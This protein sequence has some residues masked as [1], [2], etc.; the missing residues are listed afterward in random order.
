MLISR[1]VQP[2]VACSSFVDVVRAGAAARPGHEAFLFLKDGETEEGRRTLGDLEV[3]ARRIGG[4]LQRH[5]PP[6]LRALLLYPPG[7]EFID[8]FLGCLFAG[9]IAVPAYPPRS[10]RGLPRLL[11]ILKD[12]RPTVILTT[13]SLRATLVAAVADS[14]D[15]QGLE[16]LATDDLG[17]G[18]EADWREPEVG[19]D[20]P[21]F[22]QYTSG[23]TSLPKGVIVS[24]GNLLHNEE[25]IRQAFRQ[26]GESVV[27]SWLPLYHDMGLIGGVLQPLFVGARCVLLSPVAFLQRP[28]RWLEAIDRYR[29]TTSGGPNFAYELCV[30]KVDPGWR[31]RLDLSSW[32]VAFNGAEPVRADTLERFARHFSPCGFRREAFYPCY[33]LAEATLL[34][35]AHAAATAPRVLPLEVEAL[36]RQRVRVSDEET[37]RSR[38]L[39]ASGRGY[40]EIVIVDGETAVRLPSDQIGEIWVASPSVAQG[41]WNRPEESARTFRARL[42]GEPE[43]GPFLRTGDLGFLE[44]GELFVTGRLK[45][46]IILR[47]RNY[48]PQDFEQTSEGY[49]PHFRRGGGAAFAVTVFGE[50]QLVVVQEVEARWSGDFAAEAEALRREVA[51][52]HGIQPFEV[53]LVRHGTVPRTSSG[54]VQ[55]HACRALYEEGTLEVLARHGAA[56]HGTAADAENAENP[57]IDLAGAGLDGLRL[58]GLA[59]TEQASFVASFLLDRVAHVTGTAVARIVLSEAPAN[60]GVDSLG[61]VELREAIETSLG[62]SVPLSAVMEAASLAALRDEILARLA[63]LAPEPQRPTIAPAPSGWAS[64][65][66]P[67][68]EGQNALWVAERLAPDSGVCNIAVAARTER[69]MDVERLRRAL[70]ALIDRHPSLR[71]RFGQVGGV[72]T[73][74]VLPPPVPVD[75]ALVGL[76]APTTL[77]TA[78]EDEAEF[79][80]RLA[81][82][83]FRP[84]DLETGPLVRVRIYRRPGKVSVLLFVVHHL[85]TDYWSLAVFLRELGLVYGQGE[86]PVRLPAPAAGRSFADWVYWQKEMLAGAEGRRLAA[87]W[88]ERL[89][90]DL[91]V[92]ELPTDRPRPFVQSFIAGRREVRIGAGLAAGVDR[93]AK[94]R[95]ATLYVTLL[96]AYQA[97]LARYTGT[98]DILVGSATSGRPSAQFAGTIGYFVNMVVLRASFAADPPFEDHLATARRSML[99]ALEHQDYPFSLLAERLVTV[100]D[101]GRAPLVQTTLIFQ[102]ANAHDEL[103]AFSMGVEGARIQVG[104]LDFTALALPEGRLAFDLILSLA[105]HAAGLTGSLSYAAD[106]FDASTVDRLLGHFEE[107]LHGVVRQPERRIA[108]LPL[109]SA[110]ERQQLQVEWNDSRFAHVEGACL[111]HFFEAQAARSPEATAVVFGA[112]VLSY[113]ELAARANQLARSL[114]RLGVGPE[115]R[116]G[117][118]LERSLEMVLA[119]YGILKAGGAYVPLDPEY[120]VERLSYMLGDSGLSV[121]LTQERHRERFAAGGARVVCLDT[122]WE[123]IGGE[124]RSRPEVRV[125][126]DNM[127]Y[128]MYTSGSTGRPKGVMIR[129][130]GITSHMQWMQRDFPLGGDDSVIQK[131]PISFDASV[132]E[133]YASLFTGGRLVLA[134]P[135]GHRDPEYLV[136]QLVREQV[137]T[138]QVVPSLLRLLLEQPEMDRCQSLRWLICG[139][140]SLGVDLVQGFLARLPGELVNVYGPTEGSITAS[141]WFCRPA[142]AE[143]GAVTIGR[144]IANVE[145]YVL[146]PELA[147]VPVGVSGELYF[148]GVGV[149]RGYWGRPDLTAFRFVPDPL[150]LRPGARLYRTGDRVRW[151]RE[152]RLEFLGRVDHQVKLRGFRIELG[153]IEGILSL[154]KAVR[155]SV[156]VVRHDLAGGPRLVGY[157]SLREEGVEAADLRGHL[158]GHLPEHMVPWAIEILPSLP[159]SPSGKV[160]RMALPLPQAARQMSE[161]YVAPRTP[162]EIALAQIWAEV[163]GLPQVGLEDSFFALGGHSLLAARVVS[164]LRQSFGVELPLR[165][166]FEQPTVGGLAVRIEQ[167]AGEGG[168]MA[169]PPLGRVAREGRS[170]PLSFAQQRLWFLHQ[171]E[172]ASALYNVAA[173]LRLAGVLDVAAL[174][175]SLGEVVRRHEALRTIFVLVGGEPVQE[176]AER[177]MAP[178]P[179]VNLAGLGEPQ[180]QREVLRLTLAEAERPFDLARGP[181]LRATLLRLSAREH[182]LLVTQHHIASDGW[183]IGVLTREV[184]SLYASFL[185]GNVLSLPEL[186]VQYADFAVWQREWLSGEVLE[187]QIAYWR[188]ALSGLSPLALPTDRPRPP[189]RRGRGAHQ[190]LA[191]EPALQHAL[192]RLA[193]ER[194]ATPFMVLLAGLATLLSRLSGQVDVVVGTPVANRT[195]RELEDLIGFFVNTLVLRADL[196]GAPRFV[197]VLERLRQ[198]SLAAY[199]HQDLPFE[200]VVEALAPERDESR[201]P[202]FQVL[203]VLQ[204]APADE[205]VLPGLTL[206]GLEVE[207]G[208]AKFDLTLTLTETAAGLL[209]HWEF[210]RDLFERTTLVRL[211]GQLGRLLAGAVTSPEARIGDLPLLSEVE[212]QQLREWTGRRAVYPEV[213]LAHLLASQ[214]ARTPEA[215][216]VVFAGEALSYGELA[217]RAGVLAAELRS[218]GVGPEVRVGIFA[219]RSLALLV[220]LVAILE[221][222]G[223]YVP[224]DPSYPVE[225]LAFM[226]EDSGVTVLL[227]PGK[228]AAQLPSLSSRG[229]KVVELDVLLPPGGPGWT[230]APELSPDHLAYMIYT[231]GS[232]GRPKGAMNSHRGIVNRLLWMAEHYRM[233]PG[234]RI[235]QKTPI[236]F[237][238]S[239]W[240]L[241]LPLL[242]GA[243]LVVARPGGH[244][245]PAYLVETVQREEITCL[246]FVPAML[247]AFLEAPGVEGCSSL[248]QVIASGEALGDELERRFFARLTTRLDNL[249]GPTEAAVDVT[250]WPCSAANGTGRV[251]IGR[252]V[253][254]T[255][256][257]VLDPALRPVPPGAFGELAIGGVQVGRGYLGRPELTAE[258]FVPDPGGE[259][260]GE[261]LYLTGDLVRNL[262]DGTV[263]YV[264]RLDHQVKVRG[265]RIEL[266]ELESVLAAHPAVREA[267]VLARQD[268]PGDVRLVAYVVETLADAAA[269]AP[270]AGLAGTLRDHLAA[271]LPAYM[272]PAAFV[273]LQALP[274]N[275]SGKVDRRALPTPEWSDGGGPLA[276]RRPAE[277][278]LVGIWQEV[279]GRERLGVADDFFALGGHSLLATQVVARVR[280]AFAVELPVRALFEAPTVAELARR[281]EAAQ[282]TVEAPAAPPLGR[283]SRDGG[284][285][286]L[287]LSFGQERLWF[288]S[289]LEPGSSA[290]NLPVALEVSGVLDVPAFAGSCRAIVA[291][292]EALRTTFVEAA[293]RGSQ[294][295]APALALPVPV[296][297]LAVLPE[298]AQAGESARLVREDAGRPFDLAT[299]PLLRVT[300]LRLA[301]AE[302]VSLF[303]LHH[304]V[305]DGWSM[306][307]FLRELSALYGAGVAGRPMTL[308]ELPIQYADFALWQH[309]WLG[310]RGEDGRSALAEQLDYW[311][312]QLAGAPPVFDLPMDRPRPAERIGRGGLVPYSLPAELTRSARA[313]ARRSG[314]TLFMT[315]VA[316]FHTLLSRYSGVEDIPLGT[317]VANRTHRESEGLIGFFVNTLVLRGDLAGDPSFIQLL[318]RTR[319]MLFGAYAHQDLPFEKL[320]DDLA[321]ARSLSYAPIFQVMIALQNMPLGEL[322]LPGLSLASLPTGPGVAKF[323]LTLNL[324]EGLGAGLTG[325][326]QYDLDLFDTLRIERLAGHLSTLLKAALA[327]PE[328]PV[329]TL[330]L[331]SA[332]ERYQLVTGWNETRVDVAEEPSSLSGLVEAQVARTPEA[333]AVVDGATE[334][335]YGELNRRANR[336]ARRLRRLGIG[337]EKRVGIF[338]ERSADLVVSLLASL[339]SGGAY[340]SLDPSYP[341][342]R[343]AFMVED[344]GISVIVVGSAVAERLPAALLREGVA[345]LRLETEPE[346]RQARQEIAAESG[347]DLPS[348]T[349][350][351]HLS[352]VIYTSGST[353][354]PKGVALEH[355]GAV[356]LC[357]WA[358]AAF[359][360]EESAVVGFTT[361]VSFDVSVFELF[362]ALTRGGRLVVAENVLALP[363]L[364]AEGIT[365]LC[366]VPSA[367]VELVRLGG[368]P[369]SVRTFCLAGEALPRSLA[370]ALFALDPTVRVL[371]VY[372]PSEDTTY[373]TLGVAVP[374]STRPPAIGRPIQN[375]RTYVLDRH[376]EPMPAGVPGELHLGGGGLARG[377]LGLPDLTAER[378]IP[379]A[380]SEERGSRLYRTGDLARVGFDGELEYLG[381]T[382]HQVKIRGFRIEL[383]EIEA[384]LRSHPAVVEAVVLPRE[385][386]SGD[387]RLVAYLLAAPETAPEAGNLRAHLAARLPDYMVPAAFVALAELPLTPSGKLDRRTLQRTAPAPEWGTGGQAAEE[388]A[389]PLSPVAEMVAGIWA[390]I[391]HRDRVG[392]NDD[393]FA[394]GGHSLLATQVVA[395]L[396]QVLGVELPLRILFE[397]PTVATLSEAVEAVL[398]ARRGDGGALPPILPVPRGEA[399][400]LSF[401]QERLWFVHQ[402]N[403]D[404]D[405]YNLPAAV[406]LTGPTDIAALAWSFGEIVRRHDSLR[407]RF[408]LSA[409]RAVQVVDPPSP[410]SPP[411]QVPLP[412]VDLS[413]LGAERREPAALA[414]VGRLASAPFDL[415][416]GPLLRSALLRLSA[417][418]HVFALSL[419]HIIT[420]GWSIDLLLREMTALYPARVAG[421][422]S[423]LKEPALQF[424]DFAA[425]QRAGFRGEVLESQLAYWRRA[426]AAPL[427]VL[428]LPLDFERPAVQVFA[429]GVES[430]VLPAESALRLRALARQE[431]VTPF[432]LLLA[433]FALLLGRQADQQDVILGSPIAGRS[434]TEVEGLLGC[435]LNTVALRV[436]L[437]RGVSFRALLARVR[438]SVLDAHLHQDLPFERLVEELRPQRDLGRHPIFDVLINFINTPRA[439]LAIPGLELEFVDLPE[440][441]S[442][443]ALT[444]YATDAGDALALRLAYQRALFSSRRIALLMDQLAFLLDQAAAAP[445]GAIE[446][447]SLV[448]PRSFGLLPDPGAV[449]AEPDFPSTPRL[450]LDWGRRTP[451]APALLQG[452]AVLT[453]G[454]LAAQGRS[455]ARALGDRGLK[456]GD[457]VAVA[458]R[459]SFD[460]IA[461]LVGVLAGGGVLLMLD[462]K[463]P[464]TRRG[465]M[466]REARSRFLLRLDGPEDDLDAL[467][468]PPET[469][470][471][472]AA[473]IFA[474]PVSE[475]DP[476]AA[477]DE[478]LA[479]GEAAYIFFTSGTTGVPK[480]ILGRHRGLSH[481][482][483]WQRETFE[484]GPGD[485]SA[486]LTGLSF[487]VVLRDIF[488]PL[489]SGAAL[490][491]PESDDLAP[492]SILS[493]LDASRISVLHTV[494]ALART[495]LANLP[496]GLALGHLRWVFFAGEVLPRWLV[497]KWRTA[498]PHPH[499]IVNL[500]GPTETTL[501][502]FFYRVPDDPPPGVQPVGEPLP[503][504]QGLVLAADGRLCGVGEPGEIVVRTP[505]RSLGYVNPRPEDVARFVANPFRDDPG[506]L[507][508]HTGDKGRYRPDGRLDILGRLDDLVKVRGIRVEPAEVQAALSTFPGVRASEVLARADA[509]GEY[510][511]TAYF[512]AASEP[513]PTVSA[514]RRFLLERLPEAMVPTAFVRLDAIPLTAN[515]KVDRSRL[516]EPGTSRPELEVAY[517][518]P[519]TAAERAITEVWRELLGIE[520]IGLDDNFFDLGG[521]SLL[522]IEVRGR[523]EAAL[524]RPVA[525]VDLFR[526][527]SVGALARSL[528]PQTES[529]TVQ[530]KGFDRGADRQAARRRLQARAVGAARKG[531]E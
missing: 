165:D 253:A 340:V 128:V 526:F 66:L 503:Q 153:E 274:L 79:R 125:G 138:L 519:Q 266:G 87:F 367:L 204:N 487:D 479:L 472:S 368:V 467:A 142:D 331:L 240:E 468:V 339:K 47:G 210:D 493:W 294:V 268:T 156:V 22:L 327:A 516:P 497:E 247:S 412:V 134:R 3:W 72:P 399:L 223:G 15:W 430:L 359:T 527:P 166:L 92:L 29:G 476:A 108:D 451:Q 225:R 56:A 228:L 40:A 136:S 120:P 488:L 454:G 494:P 455:V 118:G 310:P 69:E 135:G 4:L 474:G 146:G 400:P 183:S 461:A 229:T 74:G 333:V 304:I 81:R 93:L 293:G 352:Y 509:A 176:I 469:G 208:T 256:I 436:D 179:Q 298:P 477:G 9:A 269:A 192:E 200:K 26:S 203:F 335:T 511:L 370:D 103:A 102:Q 36:E 464:A 17:P 418:E 364:A 178:L 510:H 16:I 226:L 188:Q 27:V 273:V 272:V 106:L 490:C 155:E 83:A 346:A 124:S 85:V 61:G 428:Q 184:G 523:L 114:F 37:A 54:K 67:L 232:T 38:P 453:Y 524:G 168:E 41:Y 432:M 351:R 201:T 213:T 401:A 415:A 271:R 441:E 286:G 116:V 73:Q 90:G 332:D 303:N 105:E 377:Y 329:S 233:G 75:L 59:A 190:P 408:P 30:R 1:A 214:A 398:R 353:G 384:V 144:P 363:A 459:R 378:F 343:L 46:L 194:G 393:F 463:L 410:P 336:L 492:E 244:Q 531:K 68:A 318:G 230:G 123:A 391:L 32:Q 513:A 267:V 265:F 98:A 222:G 241:F 481:F 137:T 127:A 23:S 45:D 525:M 180:R 197:D 466:L 10:M 456:P 302:H 284:A 97:L 338:V 385:A 250:F 159:L 434:R 319:E 161:Q 289:R 112:T 287:P 119:L 198:V 177:G 316:A 96:A 185:A 349:L 480:G 388:L 501:A 306:G 504:T 260:G 219:E 99:D 215:V 506:D 529:R 77:E 158:Q 86:A 465:V 403:P 446:S 275:P 366:A 89:A 55:R 427:P 471:L 143:G 429:G 84:F 407:T 34:V 414:A 80:R 19:V 356:L 426:L 282:G 191:L 202:L 209:G 255:A 371:N 115:V 245:E 113:G 52:E 522:L 195:H 264:G 100:R 82:E 174:E 28:G 354:Q 416:S 111:H 231:S 397:R 375:G 162:V 160:D 321:P 417:K 63:R 470:V 288:L 70:E 276:P 369:A 317:A 305:S 330:P 507:V 495:W 404:G 341:A 308:P 311:R 175:H 171:L 438:E 110:S 381:R 498:F 62:I 189:R 12:A 431:G 205:L 13:A 521:H 150:S 292:H 261:R 502:K 299:G 18:A 145:I 489:T 392:G 396:R 422:P 132:W 151:V 126:G 500:Y 262:V 251:P 163:L 344:S 130:A 35:S 49:R 152:G 314:T 133:F 259:R 104:E 374:D 242:S 91:P 449:L 254:N 169:A 358:A 167:L 348:L 248:R 101:P 39:V 313:F 421:L 325:D 478:T 2:S 122:E 357:R 234:D 221:A 528:T 291:R 499:G 65:E 14:P 285:S 170:L 238:V 505:F 379:D 51:S 60:L 31:E 482:L 71:T 58:D 517:L 181:L 439:A 141:Y 290:Y 380:L 131:T 220:G 7:V 405:A 154:H 88:E 462:P 433:G 383:G 149:G 257:L 445:E 345:V 518:A 239:V 402:L 440:P 237:D 182:R 355:R 278:I 270:E 360:A 387:L 486:Q 315:L 164:R 218:C 496:A 11:S 457:V 395:R 334:I 48:Y 43:A 475:P 246:H 508:Y 473:E 419:H 372:G 309:R 140:E 312:R 413:A 8:A 442:K 347:E 437:T 390:E 409:G 307:V 109:L 25:M 435:F 450:I 484:V 423:P 530:Q 443:F 20:T 211:G 263:E 283:T 420:D 279:L 520:Q 324:W 187:R 386:A 249:Y 42:A 301:A 342:E 365:L 64:G 322:A 483:A 448:S 460:L 193:R 172:P 224:L 394:L 129:H 196:A 512:V 139:G 173:E 296:V 515:G 206:E 94:S 281:V 107:L 444:L 236:S 212:S 207:T 186:P 217:A 21:A 235:L 252:P 280:G 44:G 361:S 328:Q 295:I 326:L 148:G 350:P 147:P 53:V 452:E 389:T 376:G 117:L 227:A 24:H 447:Y 33:G 323:D 424:A 382:D 297:D 458:G 491:L 300:L 362:L 199:A 258:R 320:V 425:W 243:C 5:G 514:L 121:V 57:E 157:V 78:E 6:G 337:P 277:E 76:A 216:A 406:R 373:S 411:S 50:E 95:G 485:R